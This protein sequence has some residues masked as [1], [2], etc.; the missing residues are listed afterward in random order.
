MTPIQ[1]RSELD[2]ATKPRTQGEAAYRCLRRDIRSGKLEPERWLR[3]NELQEAYGFGWSPLRE[4]L[5]LLTA[6][7]LVL[8][9]GQR[10]FMVAPISEEDFLDVVSLR[11]KLEEDAIALSCERGD[12]EW[13]AGIV[14][15]LHRVRK[16]PPHWEIDDPDEAEE[17]QR[18]HHAFHAALLAACPSR[19]TLR[20]WGTLQQQVER[21][22]RIVLSTV[23]VPKSA[24]ATIARHHEKIADAAIARQPDVAIEYLRA[25]ED[26]SSQLIRKALAEKAAR[27]SDEESEPHDR[28][29]RHER[30]ARRGRKADAERVGDPSTA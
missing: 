19:W 20:I 27:Q 2:R 28:R 29:H 13:E 1:N 9:E 15:A 17:Q 7:N 22:Q 18:R 8:S 12:D 30:P 21:Y 11:N 6:E 4:A 5:F 10:G 16:L 24:Q 3:L 26:W 25:H 23:A 14:S